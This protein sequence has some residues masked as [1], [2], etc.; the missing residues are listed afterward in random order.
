MSEPFIRFNHVSK[1]YGEGN[2]LVFAL[3]NV[4]F[5]IKEGVG[6]YNNYDKNG[7]GGA[8]SNWYIKGSWIF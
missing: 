6:M 4:S 7:R 1:T 8:N 2:S 5:E 3:K